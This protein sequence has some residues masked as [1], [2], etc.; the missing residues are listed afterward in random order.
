MKRKRYTKEDRTKIVLKIL[1]E[2]LE[3]KKTVAEALE[4]LQTQGQQALL[5]AL[6]AELSYEVNN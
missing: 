2:V 6:N 3:G 1:K 4:T 5:A